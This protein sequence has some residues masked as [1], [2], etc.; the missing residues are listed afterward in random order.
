MKKWLWSNSYLFINSGCISHDVVDL[1]NTYIFD[2]FLLLNNIGWL[3]DIMAGTEQTKKYD[4]WGNTDKLTALIQ[5]IQVKCWLVGKE[6]EQ[7]FNWSSAS[8]SLAVSLP[9]KGHS[10]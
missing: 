8:I 3:V 7:F 9:L 10:L 5:E 6:M 4:V 2:C 1:R